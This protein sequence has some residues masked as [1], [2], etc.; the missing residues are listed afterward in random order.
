MRKI[1]VD[2]DALQIPSLRAV[3]FLPP[4]AG[5]DKPRLTDRQRQDLMRIGTRIRLP[6]RMVVYREH[7]S[8]QC[9]FAIGEGVVKSYREFP[10][11]KRAVAAF[12]FSRDVFGLAENGRY[13]NS[14]QA[15]SHV[16]LY[17]LPI[18]D[19]T[20]LLKHDAEL[21]FQFLLKVTHE[22]RKA[23]RRAI[24]VNR[25]DA[26]G[27]FATFISL[28]SEHCDRATMGADHI[29]LPMTRSDIASFLGLSLESVSRAA[30]TLRQK[31]L[32]QFDG[33]HVARV[34]NPAG[35]ARLVAAV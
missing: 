17:R 30:A 2:S 7:A 9:V 23:Q 3:P 8:A 5:A 28:M 12:L 31:G 29:P 32:V 13:I 34:L 6:A 35:L 16:T 22:L 15:I 11:G 10:S 26:A 24:L 1:P 18:A 27:R 20:L 33:L 19:L 21:Q 4:E 25:R 14:V